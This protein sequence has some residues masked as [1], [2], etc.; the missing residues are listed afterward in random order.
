MAIRARRMTQAATYWPP[1]GQDAFGEIQHGAPAAV[2]VRWQDKHELFRDTQARDV[3]SDAIA[4]VNTS[5]VTG[6]RLA[7]GTLTDPADGLEIRSV[8]N[9]P[10]LDGA[11]TLVKAWM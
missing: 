9:S 8:G 10:S 7:L 1:A 5:V 4:Y 6:G 11:E 3:M 2:M